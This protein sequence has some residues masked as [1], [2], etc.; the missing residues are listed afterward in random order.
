[1]FIC[2]LAIAIFTYSL[3]A[4]QLKIR[5]A[6]YSEDAI[7]DEF[8][9]QRE[10]ERER[11]Q[12]FVVQDIKSE[13][14]KLFARCLYGNCEMGKSD[15][16]AQEF[17][18]HKQALIDFCHEY[19]DD[20]VNLPLEVP[21]AWVDTMT[22]SGITLLNYAACSFEWSDQE[23]EELLLIPG[24]RYDQGNSR[25]HSFIYKDAT[26]LMYAANSR[27]L[28]KVAL[29]LRYGAD[30]DAVDAEER[31]PLHWA[32][33]PSHFVWPDSVIDDKLYAEHTEEIITLLV[34]ADA[35]LY[36]EAV[37]GATPIMLAD[38]VYERAAFQTLQ[39]YLVYEL[40]SSQAQ[41][42]LLALDEKQKREGNDHAINGGS[43]DECLSK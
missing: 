6:V 5:L 40:L 39:K 27:A 35:D 10:I 2:Y 43:V 7:V 42:I 33:M 11:V 17:F 30:I 20:V 38:T 22:L 34:D 19:G 15:L 41:Q 29:L 24:I 13:Y 18:D 31:S 32:A 12:T 9:K 36:A 21:L 28:G 8:R 3:P 16:L 25:H 14:M 1:V 37:T 23:F 26:P 4:S